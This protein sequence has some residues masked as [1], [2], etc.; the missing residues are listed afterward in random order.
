MKRTTTFGLAAAW[1]LLAF[2]VSGCT[3]YPDGPAISFQ[4]AT[5]KISTTWRIDEASVNGEEITDQFEGDFLKF[6]EDGD[7]QVFDN[8]FMV[9]LP[10]FSQDSAVSMLGFGNWEFLDGSKY[11]ELL[12]D[13]RVQDPYNQTVIYEQNIN[14]VWQVTR[15]SDDQLWLSNDST[16]LKLE[17]YTQ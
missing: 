7:F 5:S 8:H 4:S 10:P 14:Q 16:L 12:Y 3:G 13:F 11:V 1:M 2:I 15:L 6:E 17:F 9:S